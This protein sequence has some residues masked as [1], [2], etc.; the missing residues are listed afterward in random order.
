MHSLSLIATDCFETSKSGFFL[1]QE[2]ETESEKAERFLALIAK[3][4]ERIPLEYLL[5]ETEF[6]GLPFLVN[7]NVLIV[8][9]TNYPYSFTEGGKAASG[10]SSDEFSEAR[11]KT[12]LPGQ[13]A[14]SAPASDRVPQKTRRA[15]AILWSASGSQDCGTALARTIFGLSAPAGRTNETW[16]Q[17]DDQLP[18]INDYDVIKGRRTYRYFDGEVIWPFGYGLTYTDFSYNNLSLAMVDP[19]LIEASFEVTNTGFMV[20]DEVAELYAVMPRTRVPRPLRQ[21]VGFRRLHDVRPGETVRVHFRIPTAEL[22]YYDTISGSMMTEKGDYLFFA[23]RSSADRQTEKVLHI[24]GAV[25]GKRDTARRIRADHYD[26]YDNIELTEKLLLKSGKGCRIQFLAGNKEVLAF[27]G[28]TSS[29][30]ATASFRENSL[31]EGD[32][33]PERWPAVWDEVEFALPDLE[34][35]D[36]KNMVI[37][38]RMEGDVKLLSFLLYRPDVNARQF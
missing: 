37:T 11:R 19:S 18:D 6:M 28:D 13:S 25:P 7:E 5:G 16:Y 8:F 24:P 33:A 35:A 23:G 36:R 12:A 10:L 3:R 2:L 17:S 31:N 26:D 1:N 14:F 9:L 21:L 22:S 30:T 4:C 27:H 15:K 29:Y 32:P 34:E 20:S 38:I